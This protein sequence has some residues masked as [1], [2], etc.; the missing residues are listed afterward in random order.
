MKL[1]RVESIGVF[2]QVAKQI[3]VVVDYSLNWTKTYRY[4]DDVLEAIAL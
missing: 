2:G 3:A 1:S 4:E